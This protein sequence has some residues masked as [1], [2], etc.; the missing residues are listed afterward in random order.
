MRTNAHAIL[1][2]ASCFFGSCGGPAPPKQRPAA[3]VSDAVATARLEAR[4]EGGIEGLALA[5]RS[6]RS[7]R[8]RA[9][10]GIGRIGSPRA[11]SLLG[12]WLV[13]A[14][15]AERIEIARA[16]ALT[17]EPAAEGPLLDAILHPRPAVEAREMKAVQER[18]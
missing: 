15:P 14:D 11:L 8:A 17:G 5:F 13:T 6:T 4:R 1:A 7:E 2:C 18:R 9:V 3:E 16:L 10:R 12:S